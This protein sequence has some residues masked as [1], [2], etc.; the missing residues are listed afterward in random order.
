MKRIPKPLYKSVEEIEAQIEG[1]ELDA[2][3]AAP[4]SEEHREI[5]RDNRVGDLIHE[6]LGLAI[7]FLSRVDD[8]AN[9]P[10]QE[11]CGASPRQVCLGHATGGKP[12]RVRSFR[13][14]SA[15]YGLLAGS[16]DFRPDF[17]QAAR[18]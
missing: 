8:V 12:E 1:L 13:T 10:F 15:P 11:R 14:S 7:R 6:C 3:R 16:K 18:R 9:E 2:I 17:C 4:D 5:M